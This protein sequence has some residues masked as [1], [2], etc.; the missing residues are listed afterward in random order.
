M[1][2]KRHVLERAQDPWVVPVV[3][4]LGAAATVLDPSRVG[5]NE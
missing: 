5:T 2:E 1:S 3:P 4:A